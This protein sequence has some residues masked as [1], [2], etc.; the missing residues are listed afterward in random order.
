MYTIKTDVEKK[1][2]IFHSMVFLATKKQKNVQMKP[3]PQPASLSM[4]MM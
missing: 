2:S 4:G 1:E 3:S